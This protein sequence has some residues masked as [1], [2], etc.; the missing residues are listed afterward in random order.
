MDLTYFAIVFGAFLVAG[1][2]K[3]TAGM[4]LPPTAIALIT[5]ALPIS[6]AL[7][8]MTVPT[9]ATNVWQAFLGGHFRTML[10]RFWVMG[11][12]IT[13]GIFVSALTLRSL[14]SPLS[15]GLL[16]VILVIFSLT[17]FVAWR[18]HVAPR[19]EWWASPLSGVATG[20]VGGVTGMAAVPFLPYMQSLSLTRDELIQA[21]GIL[22]VVFTGALTIALA[23]AGAFT[24]T[25]GIGTI[26]ATAPTLLGMWLGQKLRRAVSPEVFRRIFLAVM[27]GVGIHLSRG[28]F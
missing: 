19:H 6:D 20:L 23:D 18:P 4:G 16:G 3:G 22:F 11:I 5:L 8:L 9:L 17:A 27:F 1:L 26:V 7:A 21:L 25:N 10:R 15:V 2:V 12:A 13:I 24:I 14:G 28:L